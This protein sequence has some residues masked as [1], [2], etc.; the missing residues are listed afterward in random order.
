MW[1]VEWDKGEEEEQ[2][3]RKR[4]CENHGGN[5]IFSFVFPHKEK[6]NN[7]AFCTLMRSEI[8]IKAMNIY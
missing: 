1:A 4:E 3:S 5:R 8:K 7:Q 6:E 2:D